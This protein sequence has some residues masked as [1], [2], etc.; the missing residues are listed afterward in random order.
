MLGNSHNI[1]EYLRISQSSEHQFRHLDDKLVLLQTMNMKG[2]WHWNLCH[3]QDAEFEEFQ[4]PFSV[5]YISGI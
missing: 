5:L 2:P 1:L 3:S 4:L